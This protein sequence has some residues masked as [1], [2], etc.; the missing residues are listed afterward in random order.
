M[1]S[2]NLHTPN[3]SNARPRPPQGHQ[4]PQFD[5]IGELAKILHESGRRAVEQHKV[6]N[7]LGKPFLSWSEISEEA[8]EGRRMMAQFLLSHRNLSIGFVKDGRP[9]HCPTGDCS[10]PKI[11]VIEA[12]AYDTLAAALEAAERERVTQAK[13]ALDWQDAWTEAHAEIASLTRELKEVTQ[14][15]QD[16]TRLSRGRIESLCNENAALRE[17]V[18]EAVATGDLPQ[19]IQDGME[20]ALAKIDHAKSE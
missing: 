4:T 20:R 9:I 13:I 8:R 10:N 16:E 19:H 3:P 14:E 6:V 17:V 11:E 5:E 15:L 12:V 2:P 7:D 1:K 18:E